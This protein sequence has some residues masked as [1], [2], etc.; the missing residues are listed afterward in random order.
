MAQSGSDAGYGPLHADA[1]LRS[2]R[3][4]V[5][6]AAV[7]EVMSE[8]SAGVAGELQQDFR[9]GSGGHLDAL[10]VFGDVGEYYAAGFRGY[11]EVVPAVGEAVV[12]HCL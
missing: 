4:V 2:R 10:R 7:D 12:A 8:A 11:Q 9:S 5:G 1:L 3:V 6:D